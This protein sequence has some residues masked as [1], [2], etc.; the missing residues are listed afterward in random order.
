MAGIQPLAIP[1]SRARFAY[2]LYATN[3]TYAVAAMV[4]VKALQR[5]GIDAGIDLVVLHLDVSPYLVETMRRMGIRPMR[6]EPL[7][8]VSQGYYRDCLVRLRVFQLVQYERVVCFDVDSLPL[9]PIHDLFA[10]SFGQPMAATRAYWLPGSC[11]TY[12]LMAAE[13]SLSSF[14][15]CA[16]HFPGAAVNELYDMDILNLEF[17]D[18]VHTLPQEYFALNSEWEEGSGRYCLG[19]QEERYAACRLIHFTALGKPWTHAPDAVRRLRPRAHPHF[20]ELWERWWEL[21]DEVAGS[22]PAPSRRHFAHLRDHP[23][24]HGYGSEDP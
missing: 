24:P 17:R 12:A 2:A 13:P 9:Q 3:D 16:R 22:V 1:E 23:N 15:R 11:M 20:H 4:A 18:E 19:G 7:R 10:M 14:E 8:H 21:R 5:L 6:V